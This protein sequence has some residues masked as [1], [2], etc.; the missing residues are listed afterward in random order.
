MLDA[1]LCYRLRR[2]VLVDVSDADNSVQAFQKAMAQGCDVVTAN[3]KPL[4]GPYAHHQALMAHCAQQ[5]R[6]LRAEATVGAGLPVLDTLE[7]LLATGDRLTEAEGCLSG[8]L[9]FVMD[10]LTQGQ[11]FSD[12]VAEAAANG[13][14]E[15]DPVADLSGEDVA[16]KSVILGRFSGL[17]TGDQ[18][19]DLQGLVDPS[20]AGLNLADLLEALQAYD[21][22]LAQRVSQARE[23]GK[24]LRYIGRV[25][26]DGITVGPKAVNLDSPLGQLEGT[27]NRIIFRSERYADRPLVITGP[28][29]GIDVTAMGVL[30]DILR[31]AAERR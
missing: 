30:G 4:A 28:G 1:L 20:L 24:V 26:A 6:L 29:A 12:V 10:R 8:T 7:M 19:V 13:Y 11:R 31:V 5:G 18:T 14:T 23:Q 27:D 2:P 22:P 21:E 17:L 9:G 16:R 15:P 25:G 3:K